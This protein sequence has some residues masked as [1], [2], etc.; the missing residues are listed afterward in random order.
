MEGDLKWLGPTIE[1]SQSYYM[2]DFLRNPLVSRDA[3][4]PRLLE[5][6]TLDSFLENEEAIEELLDDGASF[7]Y[8]FST[9][10]NMWFMSDKGKL[11]RPLLESESV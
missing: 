11:L 5:N 8:V 9:D 6:R 3:Y 2:E 1:Q 7:L 10:C 4:S